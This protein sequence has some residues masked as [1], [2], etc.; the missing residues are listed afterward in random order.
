MRKYFVILV[1]GFGLLGVAILWSQR[2]P[3]KLPIVKGPKGNPYGDPGPCPGEVLRRKANDPRMKGVLEPETPIQITLNF[4]ACNPIERDDLVLFRFHFDQEPVI[5]MARGIPGDRF[6]VLPDESTGRWKIEINGKLLKLKDG[7]TIIFGANGTHPPLLTAARERDHRLAENEV[8][9]LSNA[10]V[11]QLDSR[12]IGLI[13][14]YDVVGKVIPLAGSAKVSDS[15]PS[16]SSSVTN[17]PAEEN[18]ELE[19]PRPGSDRQGAPSSKVRVS[20]RA[21]QK[22][23]KIS[24]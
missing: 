21:P 4:Y 19:E 2:G 15:N 10:T 24:H 12:N 6:N 22:Q 1:V 5:R 13:S 8:I 3:E 16:P 9:L 7:S 14:L 18:R 23:K 11:G 20:P 17:P